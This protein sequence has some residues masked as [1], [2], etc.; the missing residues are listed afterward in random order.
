MVREVLDKDFTAAGHCSSGDGGTAAST[1][2]TAVLRARRTALV[3]SR[4]GGTAYFSTTM[5]AS[6]DF[7]ALPGVYK[8]LFLYI[9]PG[10]Y[11]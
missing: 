3:L 2:T 6:D 11:S 8:T 5:S 9:E 7:P 4:T 10:I 1:I